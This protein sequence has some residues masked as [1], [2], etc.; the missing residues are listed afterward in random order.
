MKTISARELH[1]KTGQILGRVKTGESIEV[2]SD[3]ELLA[4]LIPP[5][6]S[7]FERLLRAGHVR[8][9]TTEPFDFGA[10]PRITSEASIVQMQND[11]RRAD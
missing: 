9:A 6:T 11:V 5:S 8:L 4:T 7:P 10:L 1:N 2:V 3:G